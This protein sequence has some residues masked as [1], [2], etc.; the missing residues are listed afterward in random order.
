MALVCIDCG[1]DFEFTIGEKKFYKEK[2][3]SPPRRCK[4]CR[5]KRR[6]EKQRKD[7]GLDI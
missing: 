4:N 1:E 3:F 5:Y 6:V 2:G 7:K